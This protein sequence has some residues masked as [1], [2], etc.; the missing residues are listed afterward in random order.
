MASN[1]A[2]YMSRSVLNKQAA[3]F[4]AALTIL[5]DFLFNL[6]QDITCQIGSVDTNL[7]TEMKIDSKLHPNLVRNFNQYS[8]TERDRHNAVHS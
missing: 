6:H 3:E 8:K 5:G 4:N 1:E 2:L 7:M